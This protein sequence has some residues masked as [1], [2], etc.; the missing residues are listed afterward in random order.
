MKYRN[1]WKHVISYADMLTLRQR[2]SLVASPDEYAD[3]DG[4]YTVRSLYFDSPSDRALRDKIDSLSRREKFRIRY[5]N[6]DT[7]HIRLEK[8]SKISGRCLKQSAVI[9]AA[10]AQSITD[11]DIDWLKEQDNRLLVEFYSKLRSECLKPKT[12]VEYEREPFVYAPGN[13]RITMDSNIR[14]GLYCTDFL[15]PNSAL[16]PAGEPVIVLEV[17]WDEFLPD[18]IRNAVQLVNRRTA[19]FSKYQTCRIYG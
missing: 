2:L 7:S 10:Q 6:N 3:D 14:T 17:K 4:R 18:I 8:K 11:G 19:A 9:T 13:V 16:I 15:N 1:E 5:Y 12:I